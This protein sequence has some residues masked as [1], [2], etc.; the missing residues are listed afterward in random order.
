MSATRRAKVFCISTM[1]LF[2]VIILSRWGVRCVSFYHRVLDLIDITFIRNIISLIARITSSHHLVNVH[3]PCPLF[4]CVY[5]T[6]AVVVTDAHFYCRTAASAAV[7]PLLPN[8]YSLFLPFSIARVHMLH[9]LQ[10]PWPLC[11][12]SFLILI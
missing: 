6:N 5:V 3:L 2:V 1:V 10:L 7:S 11:L 8:S 9:I 12:F 4:L